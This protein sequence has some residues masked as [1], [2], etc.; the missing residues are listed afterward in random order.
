MYGVASPTARADVKPAALSDGEPGRAGRLTLRSRVLDEE[1]TVRVRLPR[2]Y[3]AEA[4]RYPVLYVLDAEWHFNIVAADVEMLSECSYINPHPTPQMIVV[5]VA[6]NDRNRDYTPTFCPAFKNMR[7]PSSGGAADFRRFLAT[8]LVPLI[9]DTYST[10]PY[11]ILGGWSLGGLFAVRSMLVGTD[12]FNA[13]IAVSP[14]LWW[15]DGLVVK[16]LSDRTAI[17]GPS[18]PT[19]LIVTLGSQ[20]K[21]SMVEKSTSQF[22]SLLSEDAVENVATRFVPVEGLGHNYSPKMAYLL[23]LAEIFD[24]WTVPAGVTERGLAA[25]D[26]YYS[27]L[28]DDYGFGIPVPEDVYSKLGW[29]LYEAGRIEESREIFQV[30]HERHPQSALASASLGAFLRES[31]EDADALRYLKL[32]IDQEKKTPSPRQNFIHDLERDVDA[33]ETQN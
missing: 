11:R 28:S 14:S 20:E 2:D 22:L 17:E 1:V 25:V 30:W 24:D 26:E 16:Q 3:D 23:G 5:G 7:F 9:D 27:A 21:N 31:G 4:S 29:G 18:R 19:K 10:H 32:A 12:V 15:D 33:L 8:E 13:Y 6:S